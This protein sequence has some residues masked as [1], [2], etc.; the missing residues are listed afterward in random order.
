MSL[1][2]RP[3]PCASV[4]RSMTMWDSNMTSCQYEQVYRL[5]N[6]TGTSV[7]RPPSNKVTSQMWTST[8]RPFF[9]ICMQNNPT[10]EATFVQA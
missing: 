4:E 6:Y 3:Q 9:G 10:D 7:I 8:S 1:M 5:T 2:T